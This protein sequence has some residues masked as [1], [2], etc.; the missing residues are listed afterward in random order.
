MAM[1]AGQFDRRVTLQVRARVQDGTGD[2]V[3][4]W[5]DLYP[6][7]RHGIPAQK[8][9]GPA[10]ERYVGA[11]LI[12]VAATVFRMRYSPALLEVYP[13]THRLLF[14]T[15]SGAVRTYLVHGAVEIGRREG[16]ALACAARAENPD[17]DLPD[18]DDA[19]P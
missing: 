1:R 17:S 5:R 14:R 12:A 8:I 13:D 11:Q 10:A 7:L 6:E 16:V 19:E 3:E 15:P 4:G 2:P 9:E 18:P